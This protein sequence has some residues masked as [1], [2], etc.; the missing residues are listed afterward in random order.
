MPSVSVSAVSSGRGA[1]L[2]S[3]E[4]IGASTTFDGCRGS[5]GGQMRTPMRSW[6]PAG[7][8]S[9]ELVTKASRVSFHL[10][11]NQ[12]LLMNSRDKS[13]CEAVWMRYDASFDRSWSC[14]KASPSKCS[15][16]LSVHRFSKETRVS[17]WGSSRETY[18]PLR[19]AT[20]TYSKVEDGVKDVMGL[21][22]MLDSVEPLGVVVS[23]A[24]ELLPTF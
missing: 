14:Q 17:P 4:C 1:V 13:P 21:D 24:N 8:S 3:G 22:V 12:E 23:N 10:I 19:K 16:K 6:S 5:W 2:G 11:R 9:S 18:V 20:V 7:I 15:G